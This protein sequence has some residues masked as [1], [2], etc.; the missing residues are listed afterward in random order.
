[1]Y[2]VELNG[3]P[4]HSYFVFLLEWWASVT[5]VFIKAF[6]IYNQLT[7][8]MWII[9]TIKLTLVFLTDLIIFI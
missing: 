3:D 2:E 1:M 6:S 5:P 7:N 4:V 8:V 9:V